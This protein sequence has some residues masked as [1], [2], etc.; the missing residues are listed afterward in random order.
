MCGCLSYV[1]GYAV[2]SGCVQGAVGGWFFFFFSFAFCASW[3]SVCYFSAVDARVVGHGWWSVVWGVCF[4]CV[5]ICVCVCSCI[6]VG[7]VMSVCAFVSPA[8]VAPVFASL[9]VL[10]VVRAAVNVLTRVVVSC[11]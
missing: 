5:W 11:E 1:F 9:V 7:A 10:F 8:G 4:V 6:P 3:I 2:V